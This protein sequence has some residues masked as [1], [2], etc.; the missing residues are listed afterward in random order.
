MV[1]SGV[2]FHFR[3]VFYMVEENLI[4]PKF[5]PQN[6]YNYHLKIINNDTLEETKTLFSKVVPQKLSVNK[7]SERSRKLLL[8]ES[9][10][11]IA[12]YWEN[13][14]NGKAVNFRSDLQLH[15]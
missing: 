8:L 13:N 4:Y 3:E 14:G 10:I 7:V 9:T 1:K 5:Y 11:E 2:S 15:W 12:V 6:L